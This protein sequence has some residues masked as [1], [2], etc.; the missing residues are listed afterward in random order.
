MNENLR[1]MDNFNKM[2]EVISKIDGDVSNLLVPSRQF[3]KGGEL[4]KVCRKGLQI[5][6]FF[7]FTDM[8]LHTSPATASCEYNHSILSNLALL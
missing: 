8:L 5:R 7:L 4:K 2:I 3:I 1:M 6:A